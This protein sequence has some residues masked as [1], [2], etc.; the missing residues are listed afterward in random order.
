M[1]WV[2]REQTTFINAYISFYFTL[3]WNQVVDRSDSI[4]LM[5][6]I[7]PVFLF[8][9][10]LSVGNIDCA[11]RIGHIN[12]ATFISNITST[13]ITYK[14]TC[15]ECLC[16]AFFSAQPPLYVGLNCYANNKTCHLFANYS[17]PSVILTDFNS[18]F[19]FVRIPPL[20][21]VTTGNWTPLFLFRPLL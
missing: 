8:F 10:A 1:H 18:T 5:K 3:Q 16:N 9:L 19:S 11:V 6:M 12:N 15:D 2:K 20:Q 14:S 21:N 17:S 4:H 7:R 13:I